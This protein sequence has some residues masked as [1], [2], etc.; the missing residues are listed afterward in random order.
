MFGDKLNEKLLLIVMASV[1]FKFVESLMDDLL[2][3]LSQALIGNQWDEY[4]LILG[5]STIKVGHL[6]RSCILILLA[7]VLSMIFLGYAKSR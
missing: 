4:K 7:L 1:L 3:P 5:T 6:L 2:I